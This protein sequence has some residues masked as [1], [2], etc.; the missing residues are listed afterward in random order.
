MITIDLSI[1][2]EIIGVLILIVVL[3][4]MLYQ[5]LRRILKQRQ[6]KMEAIEAEAVKFEDRIKSLIEDY[7][8]KLKEARQAGKD[9]FDKLRE[10]AKALEQKLLQESM[11]EA[12]SKRQELMSQLTS[13][14]EAAKKEL[15]AKAEMFAMEI[16]QKL[17]GRAI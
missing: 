17:L 9:E 4:S 13:Q 2:A 16:A 15:Q 6:E 7:E 11:Q 10:E 8:R 1:V 5:P 3:N 12:E 14:I